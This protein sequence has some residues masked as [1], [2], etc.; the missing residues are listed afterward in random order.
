MDLL[1][2]GFVDNVID[3]LNKEDLSKTVGLVYIFELIKHIESVSVE[4]DVINF[5][6]LRVIDRI[7]IVETLPLELYEK[8]TSFYSQ[9]SKYDQ[10]LLTIDDDTVIPMDASLFDAAVDA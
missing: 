6:E 9:T 4:E 2:K 1:L 7:K 3:A 5:N 8:I 10:S